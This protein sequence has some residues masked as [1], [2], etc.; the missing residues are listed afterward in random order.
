MYIY[1]RSQDSVINLSALFAQGSIDNRVSPSHAH[2]IVSLFLCLQCW[3][4]AFLT[5]SINS[6]TLPIHEPEFWVIGELVG[7][8]VMSWPSCGNGWALSS[9]K[10]KSTASTTELSPALKHQ[11][12]ERRVSAERKAY[13]VRS[14]YC[15]RS[16]RH[17]NRFC[18]VLFSTIT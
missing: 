15:Y 14:V 10:G 17:A 12:S 6:I 9:P 8:C 13:G 1:Y 2:D 7:I 5:I 16:A 18:I 11:C 4:Y 3:S